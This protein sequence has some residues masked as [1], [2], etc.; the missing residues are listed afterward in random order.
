MPFFPNDCQ[1]AVH[2]ESH[3]FAAFPIDVRPQVVDTCHVM[4]FNRTPH[5]SAVVLGHL[6]KTVVVSNIRG[7]GGN[8]LCTRFPKIGF[9]VASCVTG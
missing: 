2:I 3:L 1:K 5:F 4:L 6:R 7:E 8:S 9:S